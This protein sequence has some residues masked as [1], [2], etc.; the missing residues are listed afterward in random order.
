MQMKM[1][2]FTA[3]SD[4][5]AFD[6]MAETD[7]LVASYTVEAAFI[8]P[9]CTMIILLLIGQTLFYRDV[10]T[11]ERIA[12]T[13]AQEGVQYRLTSSALGEAKPDYGRFFSEGILQNYRTA[14]RIKDEE[15]IEEYAAELLRGK[16][17]FAYG[18]GVFAEIQ[19]NDVTV[20]ITIDAA[21]AVK[22]LFRYGNA[23][24]F[25]R[26]ASVTVQGQDIAM[27]NRMITAA[28]DTSTRISGLSEIL[29]K[30]QNLLGKII[31]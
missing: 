18:T 4:A 14:L 17:W 3:A 8:V 30:L 25:H 16:L 26:K 23:P 31:G 22:Y 13:A 7:T 21:D 2:K 29:G 24:L 11:A 1:R 6:T 19:G 27:D 15:A 5:A 28:W 12:M 9:L 10:V 20:T